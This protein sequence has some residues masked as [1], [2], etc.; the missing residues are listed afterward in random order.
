M[1][2]T[3]GRPGLSRIAWIDEVSE[4]TSVCDALSGRGPEC[5]AALAIRA[6]FLFPFAAGKTR[7]DLLDEPAV[8]VWTLKGGKR[9]VERAS[10]S[11]PATRWFSM[12]SMKGPAA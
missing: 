11:R 2:L 1:G 6:R 3:V 8:P 10:G 4:T 12:H 5:E 7:R 9:E